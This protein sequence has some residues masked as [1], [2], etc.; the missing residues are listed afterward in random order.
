MIVASSKSIYGEGS[1]LCKTHGLVYPGLRTG[2]QLMRKDWEVHCPY[3]GEYVKPTAIV[4][5][6][7]V[8]N[9]STYAL[10]KYDTERIA[11]N[12]G[13]ALRIPTIAF[14]YFNVY[15][16]DKALTIHIPA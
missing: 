4:E 7:P 8:Q 1:Y 13:F 10:S 16:L 6:K 12:F 11:V 15:G 14:R 5:D 9:L 3:C 2:E